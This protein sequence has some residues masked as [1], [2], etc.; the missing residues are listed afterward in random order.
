MNRLL[1]LFIV[2]AAC[3]F[4]T[5]VNSSVLV[6]DGAKFTFSYTGL[7]SSSCD[8]LTWYR[9]NIALISCIQENSA[10][11]AN[12]AY[13]CSE[14]PFARR[15]ECQLNVANST[16]RT[17]LTITDVHRNQSDSDEG[18]WTLACEAPYSS[19]VTTFDLKLYTKA[20]RTACQTEIKK[21]GM[22]LTCTSEGIYPQSKFYLEVILNQTKRQDGISSDCQNTLDSSMLHYTS[23][24]NHVLPP[25]SLNIGRL[26]LNVTV[27]SDLTTSLT[28]LAYGTSTITSLYFENPRITLEDCTGPGVDEGATFTCTCQRS[29][30]SEIPT[31]VIWLINGTE[32]IT[33]VNR[34]SVLKSTTTRYSTNYT[35]LAINVFGWPSSSLEYQKSIVS[36]ADSTDND[37]G[38][39]VGGVVA[40]V[41]VLGVV[42]LA[43]II[44]KRKGGCPCKDSGKTNS[45]NSSQVQRNDGPNG[46]HKNVLHQT[47]RFQINNLSS[48]VASVERS[49]NSGSTDHGGT[50]HGGTDHGGTDQGH[51][52]SRGGEYDVTQPSVSDGRHTRGHY[53]NVART[54][55]SDYHEYQEVKV[56]HTEG[57]L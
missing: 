30:N 37:V 35:C 16:L 4:H 42:I 25:E 54:T 43:V 10:A 17:N 20:K 7:L 24:C 50:D 27:Y 49:T 3:R 5:D 32:Q 29:D 1:F 53:E 41:I 33:S 21:S 14:R 26:D 45:Q 19:N 40:A 34:Y 38:A 46:K 6:E 23:V 48:I 11:Q 52:Y 28:D 9:R 56:Q 22:E 31:N 2:I 47:E 55:D 39:V 51:H 44:I 15:S 8:T 36:D 13:T 57:R 12:P 18:V